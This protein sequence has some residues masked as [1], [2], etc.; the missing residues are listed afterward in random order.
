VGIHGGCHAPQRRRFTAGNR[1]EG[2]I[3]FDLA[4]RAGAWPRGF[5][6]L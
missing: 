2:S 4:R 3:S 5:A 6:V 1:P